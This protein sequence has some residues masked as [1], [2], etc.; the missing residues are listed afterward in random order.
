MS[1]V[2]VAEVQFHPWDRS[3]F[4]DPAGFD[5]KLGDRVIVETS[6]GQELGKII[7]FGDVAPHEL[8]APL[9]PILRIP[10]SSDH[11]LLKSR[12]ARKV[13]YLDQ[14]RDYVRNLNLPMKM[15]D[16]VISFDDKRMTF[17]FT[18]N[19]R[20]DFRE[21]VKML[22][23]AYRRQ[24][25]LQQIGSRDV[26]A[27][28]GGIG[29]CGRETCCSTWIKKLDNVSSDLIHMQG[30]DYRGTER[31]SGLCGRLKCCLAYESEGYRMCSSKMPEVGAIIRTK[32]YGISK[33][34]S[35]NILTHVITI[36]AENGERKEVTLGCSKVGCSG[37]NG[38]CGSKPKKE[39]T[40]V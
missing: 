24:I 9:Q 31:L 36:Q 7:G 2:R 27:E 28:M 8:E 25:R 5:V 11:E 18:A 22:N 21:L 4:F 29:P 39:Q 33:V 26:V 38:G 37:C 12:Q 6:I 30:L 14:A 1:S 34:I 10:N 3:Y 35:R 17:A 20:V 19:S 23:T 32:Q 13:E 15:I 40:T 16:V